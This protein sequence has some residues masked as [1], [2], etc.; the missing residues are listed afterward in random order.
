MVR[1]AIWRFENVP[2]R[3]PPA[4]SA[5]ATKSLPERVPEREQHGRTDKHR[6]RN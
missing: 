4:L 5:W 2:L 1:G 6:R 3:S